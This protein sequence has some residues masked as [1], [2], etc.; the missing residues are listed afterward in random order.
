MNLNKTT[1]IKKA[2]LIKSDDY[3]SI[4]QLYKLGIFKWI[5]SYDTMKRWIKKDIEEND[6]K[7]FK[8]LRYGKGRGKRYLIKGST[9]L[10]LIKKVKDGYLFNEHK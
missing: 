6:N 3:Y 10:A 1:K 4:M 2:S 9:V 7:I 8:V 5:K